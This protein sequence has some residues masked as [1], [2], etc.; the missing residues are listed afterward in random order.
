M[1]L[2]KFKDFLIDL[3]RKM[4]V[5]E[6]MHYDYH[7]K[8]LITAKD[9]ARSMVAG[10]NIKSIDHYLSLIDSM[11]EKL[12]GYEFNQEDFEGFHDMVHSLRKLGV[13]LHFCELIHGSLPMKELGLIVEHLTDHKMNQ[14]VLEIAFYV[15][16]DGKGNFD[17]NGFLKAL[18]TRMKGAVSTCAL[19]VQFNID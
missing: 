15:F 14:K 1:K 6:F 5:L 18:S 8:N 11:D 12:A 3:N 9:F 19:D 16:S 13:A 7:N 10:M 17:S 4:L 2:P